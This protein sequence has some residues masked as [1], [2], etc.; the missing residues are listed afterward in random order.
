MSSSSNTGT[1]KLEKYVNIIVSVGAAVVIFGAWAKILHKSF[2]DIMLTV[3]LLT[4]AAIFLLY[5]YLEVKKSEVP[6]AA[7]AGTAAATPGADLLKETIEKYLD[8]DQLSKLNGNFSKF[9]AT[10]QG[11]AAM[12]DVAAVT[13]DFAGKTKEATSALVSMKDAYTTAA[14][15]VSQF[16]QAAEGSRAFHEQVQ[17][18]TKNLGALNKMYELELQ[19]S[20]NHIKAMNAFYDNL[21]KASQAMQGSVDDAKKTQ[22]QIALLAKNLGSLNSVYGNMLAAMQGRA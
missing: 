5:A 17:G 21:V 18:L 10:V 20:G 6:A 2:A 16:N 14:G 22:E 8:T 12:T 3:G 4:E 9:N 11:M 15:S 19:D 7:A 1:S 13:S